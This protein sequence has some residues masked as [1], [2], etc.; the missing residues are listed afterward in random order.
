MLEYTGISSCRMLYLCNYLGDDRHRAC[1][2]CDNDAH[3][4]MCV[5]VTDDMKQ[6]LQEFRETF[7][8]VLEVETQRSK[9]VNGVAASYYGVSNV[10]AAIHHSKYEGGSEFP[11]W[12][13]G[14]TMKAFRKHYG[15]A[16]FDLILHVPPTESGALVRNFA[17]KISRT[18][19]IPI[20]HGL[21]KTEATSPQKAFQSS[22][23][24]KENVHGKFTCLNPEEIY[25]KSILLIDDIFDSGYT[26]KEIGLYLTKTGAAAIAPLVIAKTV[27]GDI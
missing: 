19:N 16:R 7:F 10:G 15:S 1:E 22:I 2:V 4:K 11:D 3:R 27:G 25:G 18:L 24:K 14:L 6:K 17:E 20:S 23:S 21:I 9:M 8:P 5:V 13:L 12:L 26:M